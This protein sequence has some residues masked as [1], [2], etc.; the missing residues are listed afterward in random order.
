MDELTGIPL[1]EIEDVLH[2]VAGRTSR[3]APA[4]SPCERPESYLLGHEELQSSRSATSAAA[5]LATVTACTRGP[6]YRDR[7]WP[8]DTPEYLLAGYFRLLDT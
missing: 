6:R 1:W 5:S 7:G 4:A 2:T 3:A 8:A